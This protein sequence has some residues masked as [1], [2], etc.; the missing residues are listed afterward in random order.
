VNIAQ[1]VVWTGDSYEA[2]SCGWVAGGRSV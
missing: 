1:I 2:R